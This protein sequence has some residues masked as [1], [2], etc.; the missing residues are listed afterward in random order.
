MVEA[1]EQATCQNCDDK[2][3]IRVTS[4]EYGMDCEEPHITRSV[5]CRNC[6]E[7]GTVTLSKGEPRVTGIVS[8]ADASWN[9]GEA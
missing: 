2:S 7:G 6:R 1:I 8:L 3:D 9:S 5:T 4:R